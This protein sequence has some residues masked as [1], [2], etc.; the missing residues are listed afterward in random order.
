MDLVLEDQAGRVVGLEV[1]ASATPSSA[2]FRGL[3]ALAECAG[4]KFVR[5]IVL[6]TGQEVVPFAK[7]L[8]AVPLPAIWES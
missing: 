5:G 3:R 4:E 7:N 8:T 2:D 1:K 6:Y